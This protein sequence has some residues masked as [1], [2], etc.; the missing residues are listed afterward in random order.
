MKAR[1]IRYSD[2]GEIILLLYP[3]DTRILGYVAWVLLIGV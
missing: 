2:E 1:P 3:E